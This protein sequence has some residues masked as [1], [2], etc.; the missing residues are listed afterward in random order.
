MKFNN[1]NDFVMN[2]YKFVS[3]VIN[4]YLLF[5]CLS[6]TFDIELLTL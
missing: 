3:S 1:Y 4:L 5:I 6:L 2:A